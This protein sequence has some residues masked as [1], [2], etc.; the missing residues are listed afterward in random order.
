MLGN[1]VVRVL[2]WHWRWPVQSKLLHCRVQPR[3]SCSHTKPLSPSN[4]IWYK[5]KLGSKQALWKTGPVPHAPAASAHAWLVA[6]ESEIST[7]AWAQLLGKNIT[8][9]AWQNRTMKPQFYGVKD[10]ISRTALSCSSFGFFSSISGSWWATTSVSRNRAMSSTSCSCFGCFSFKC[11][12]S[13][14]PYFS[15][16]SKNLQKQNIKMVSTPT[17][18]TRCSSDQVLYK[19]RGWH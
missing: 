12:N 5:R 16:R 10:Y 15:N 4:I 17:M 9:Y 13:Y 1:V 11:P 7:V 6:K 14:P 8:T 2:E 19:S 3:A 18:K